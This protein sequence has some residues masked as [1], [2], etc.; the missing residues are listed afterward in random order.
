VPKLKDRIPKYR[1]HRR[2]GQAIVTLNQKDHYL[3]SYDSESSKL[4]YDRL[5]AEWLAH[6]RHMPVAV[7]QQPTVS[8]NKVLLAFCSAQA[9]R[10]RNAA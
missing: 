3:G 6:S 7:E 5:I 8:V 10:R 1:L 4:E 2:S 9:K